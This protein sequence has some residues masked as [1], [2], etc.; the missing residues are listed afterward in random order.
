MF[1]H[2]VLA[3]KDYSYSFLS[4]TSYIHSPK[5]NSVIL[6]C[7][8]I[9]ADI[10]FPSNYILKT[11]CFTLLSTSRVQVTKEFSAFLTDQVIH[12]CPHVK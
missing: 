4:L 3:N 6:Y 5:L 1:C 8:P 12:I 7:K 10:S 2:V 9:F 11:M